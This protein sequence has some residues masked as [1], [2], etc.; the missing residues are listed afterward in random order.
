MNISGHL[1][2]LELMI[3]GLN[4]KFVEKHKY[5]F[6]WSGKSSAIESKHRKVSFGLPVYRIF[7]L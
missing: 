2:D 4:D 5:S 3:R 1:D 6:A 7:Y